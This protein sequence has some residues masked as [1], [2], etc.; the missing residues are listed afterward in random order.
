MILDQGTG[1]DLL[2]QIDYTHL[3]III[4]TAHD[5]FAL[6]AIQNEVVDYLLKPI[7]IQD[8]QQTIVKIK[9]KQKQ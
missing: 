6:K 7:E 1:F 3:H 8:L 2:D 4:C 9:N 5:E